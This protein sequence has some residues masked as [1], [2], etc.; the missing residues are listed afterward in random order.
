MQFFALPLA[1]MMLSA[2]FIF[3]GY[4]KVAGWSGVI[5]MQMWTERVKG[6]KIPGTND[7][8][9]NPELLA[10]I[11]AYAELVG[12]IMLFIGILSRVTALGLFLF[13]I[14]A[15]V[16]GHAFWTFADAGPA[17]L[18][19]QQ[20]LKN[21]GIAGGLLLIVGAGGGAISIDG[22]FRRPQ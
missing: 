8:V 2:V 9:P 1:R 14:A 7:P 5:N 21:M 22:M 19:L 6:L 17:F 10:Q 12:G 4:A 11:S 18:Q 15:S 13:V 16:L 20:F 3:T